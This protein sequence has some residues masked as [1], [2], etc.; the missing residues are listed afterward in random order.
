M[1]NRKQ[2]LITTLLSVSF[3]LLSFVLCAE[4]FCFNSNIMYKIQDNI[5][6]FNKPIN[7]YIGISKDELKELDANTL[8]VIQGKDYDH[9]LI[10]KYMSEKEIMHLEDCM[11]LNN[12]ALIVLYVSLVIFIIT[13]FLFI[14]NKL[15]IY[16]LFKNYKRTLLIVGLLVTFLI[17][18]AL[19]DFYTFWTTFH[20]IV[21]PGNDRWLL[22]YSTDVLLMMVP[23]SFFEILVGLILISFIIVI[24]VTWIILNN[25]R[26]KIYD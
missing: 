14:K 24:I 25:L 15:S 9:V 6:L 12:K 19:I 18:F 11:Y 22:S 7:E 4:L 5:S 16:L 26:K 1:S 20:N 23:Q 3:I 21:F 2:N 13:L 8:K 17:S 10:E